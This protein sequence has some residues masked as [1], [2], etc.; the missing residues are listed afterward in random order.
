MA[1]DSERRQQEAD[2]DH[3]GAVFSV[4]GPVIVAENLL[5]CAMY[6]LVGCVGIQFEA[7]Q[8]LKDYRSVSV[9]IILSVKSFESMQ[10]KPPSRSTRKP[11]RLQADEMEAGA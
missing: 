7:L 9:M 11:V 8:M 3:Y 10:T 5:G 2:E 1:K 6:E 4:S